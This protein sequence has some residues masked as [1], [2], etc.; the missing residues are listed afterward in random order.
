MCTCLFFSYECV[1]ENISSESERIPLLWQLV[2]V[3]FLSD[4]RSDARGVNLV[5]GD[6][7]FG[8]RNR[9]EEVNTLTVQ[10]SVSEQCDQGQV[11]A[12]SYSLVCH[13]R[14]LQYTFEHKSLIAS[15]LWTLEKWEEEQYVVCERWWK[16]F[17]V[18]QASH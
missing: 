11:W 10:V 17:M 5:Q 18:K 6:R 8:T 3:L 16:E 12:T 9:E 14:T 1:H 2:V 15:D 13:A 4:Q 7:K